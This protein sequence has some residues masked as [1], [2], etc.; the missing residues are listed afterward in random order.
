MHLSFLNQDICRRTKSC[1]SCRIFIFK[2]KLINSFPGESV[3]FE[4]FYFL[5]QPFSHHAKLACMDARSK[6]FWVKAQKQRGVGES[7]FLQERNRPFRHKNN[8]K[9]PDKTSFIFCFY[10]ACPHGIQYL[11]L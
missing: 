10:G 4:L 11:E 9:S 7:A 2:T 8:F 1:V 5:H 3:A 6:I